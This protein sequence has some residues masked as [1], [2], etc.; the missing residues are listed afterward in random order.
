MVKQDRNMAVYRG[1]CCNTQIEDIN[2]PSACVCEC[3]CVCA[4]HGVP[5][6]FVFHFSHTL[7]SLHWRATVDV[8]RCASLQCV[9]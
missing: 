6:D 1:K 5:F 9:T 2:Y 7:P 8:L 4:C 3:V